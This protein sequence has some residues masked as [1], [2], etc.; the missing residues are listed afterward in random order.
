MFEGYLARSP[1][2]L[3]EQICNRT[4]RSRFLPRGV[5]TAQFVKHVERLF[6]AIERR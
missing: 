3:L 5:T 4:V 6:R 2:E 1:E